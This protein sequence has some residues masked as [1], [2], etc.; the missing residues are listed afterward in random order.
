MKKIDKI[1]IACCKR[2]FYFA[3]LCI[4]SIRYWD[5]NIPIELVIDHA[6]GD[7]DTTYLEKHWGVKRFD[8]RYKIFKESYSKLEPLFEQSGKRIFT[9]DSDIIL[10]GNI[11]NELEKIDSDFICQ[12][13][14]STEDDESLNAWWF[15]VEKLKKWDADY[16]FP[17]YAF[18]AGQL[19]TNEG[20]FLRENFKDILEF[21]NPPLLKQPV[22]FLNNADQGILNYVVAKKVA[23][24]KITI[25]DYPFF[26]GRYDSAVLKCLQVENVKAKKGRPEM[27]HYYGPKNGLLIN[28]PAE[29]ILRLY[30]KYYYQYYPHPALKYATDRF[31]RTIKNPF[32]FA[33]GLAKKIYKSLFILFF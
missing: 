25:K 23:D 13:I 27:I 6:W 20:I 12:K 30:E 22:I 32:A 31:M 26:I 10:L 1:Y 5:I 29:N 28:M 15:D 7:V 2:D 8:C 11:V 19:V 3:K 9:M 16:H 14:Y 4:S 24:N 33:K 18:Y 17:G 21:G